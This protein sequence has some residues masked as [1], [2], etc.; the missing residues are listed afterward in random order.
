VN[1]ALFSNTQR[2][3][4]RYRLLMVKDLRLADRWVFTV[5]TGCRS[6]LYPGGLGQ[7]KREMLYYAKYGVL[8]P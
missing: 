1:I 8:V 3:L 5:D 6:I 2:K 7:D 4:L